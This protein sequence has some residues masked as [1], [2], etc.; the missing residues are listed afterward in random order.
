MKL[1]SV[2]ILYR[3]VCNIVSREE[4]KKKKL[5][6]KK[7]EKREKK[8]I[9]DDIDAY[10]PPPLPVLFTIYL[11]T[12]H[13]HVKPRKTTHRFAGPVFFVSFVVYVSASGFIVGGGDALDALPI[14]AIIAIRSTV[15]VA[16]KF[17]PCFLL[18]SSSLLVHNCFKEVIYLLEAAGIVSERPLARIIIIMSCE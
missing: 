8:K 14:S 15:E 1:I 4:K 6:K 12:L 18:I 16:I 11:K 17:H 10:A 5:E 9:K 3:S 2:L 7:E 13:D